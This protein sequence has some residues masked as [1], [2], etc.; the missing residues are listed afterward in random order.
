MLTVRRILDFSDSRLSRDQWNRLAG[1]VPF[2]QWEWV[3]TWWRHYASLGQ[4]YVLSVENGAGEVVAIAPWFLENQPL[5]GRTLRFLGSGEVCSD[6]LSILVAD[7]DAE[8]AAEAIAEWLHTANASRSDHN[9]DLLHLDGGDVQ[10]PGLRA[11]LGSFEGKKCEV[12]TKPVAGCWRIAIC[13]RWEHYLLTLP[14]PHRR[15]MRSA[16]CRLFEDSEFRVF[17]PQ[18]EAG[19]ERAWNE[20]VEIHQRRR[21]SL[22]QPGCFA[23]EQ[24]AGFL[25]DAGRAFHSQGRLR[26]IVVEKNETA[27]AALFLLVGDGVAY[28]YQMGIN[29]DYMT[30]SPGWLVVAAAVKLGIENGEHSLDLLRGDEQYKG[31]MG[32]LPNPMREV[33]VVPPQLASRLRHT[34]WLTGSAVKEWLRQGLS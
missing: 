34:A 16:H 28:A 8:P 7:N 17:V 9:W 10:Q 24:F 23:K 21:I 13:D 27:V 2:R 33:R 15:H 26:L 19:L 4:L 31:R 18:D 32:A 30:E 5:N 6:Y 3:T 14:K 12:H 22:G 1:D 25:A 20:F 11:L 29:P